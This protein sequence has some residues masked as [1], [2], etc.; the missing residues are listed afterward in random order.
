MAEGGAVAAADGAASRRRTR[1]G[2]EQ[3]NERGGAAESLAAATGGG[4]LGVTS[5]AGRAEPQVGLEAAGADF[6]LTMRRLMSQHGGA[7]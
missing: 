6:M 7:D 4:T 3:P 5:T 1:R 2:A